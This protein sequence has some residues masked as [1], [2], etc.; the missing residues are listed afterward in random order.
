MLVL[1]MVTDS[2]APSRYPSALLELEFA[3][4]SRLFLSRYMTYLASEY[5]TVS[6]PR[7]RDVRLL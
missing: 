6:I 4:G 7:G 1:S 2:L 3:Q 5:L